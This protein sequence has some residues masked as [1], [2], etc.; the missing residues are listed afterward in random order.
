MGATKWIMEK[1]LS[2]SDAGSTCRFI[3]VRF[4]NV[5]GS[6]GSVVPLFISQIRRGG[7]VTVSDRD[8]TRYFMTV[9]E[10]A[11]LVLR[12]SAIGMGG[13]IFILDMGEALNIHE[14]A[15]DI[16]IL[17]GHKPDDEI[18]IEFVGLREGE[19]MHEVLVGE[20]E[21]LVPSGEDKILLAK[22]SAELPGIGEEDLERMLDLACHDRSEELIAAFEELLPGFNMQSGK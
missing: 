13:E 10:A 2:I 18:P 4:G 3:S 9:K 5:I 16:I 14:M 17:S 6:A 12:A 22:S 20:N 11:L 21:E 19:K 1:Y 7:P 15:R 8:A